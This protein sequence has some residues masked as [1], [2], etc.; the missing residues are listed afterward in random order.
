ME[1]EIHHTASGAAASLADILIDK[2]RK[3]NRLKLGV[4]TGR[5]MDA[6]YYD[7]VSKAKAQKLSF[8]QLSY[9]AL[10]EYIG[11]AE[12]DLH[13]YAHYLDFHLYNPLSVPEKN[14]NILNVHMDDYDLACREYENKIKSAGGIDVQ[15]LGV[16]TNGHIGLN[17]SGSSHDSRSRIVAHAL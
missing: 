14:R 4:A 11:L 16:G 9:F 15:V 6:V 1:I 12:N 3:N 7:L 13:S 17:E 5:T 8:M 2:V 10:D